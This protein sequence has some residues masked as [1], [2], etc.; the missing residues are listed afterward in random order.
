MATIEKPPFI[1][2]DLLAEMRARA[3]RAASGTRD[4]EDMRKAIERMNRM[5]EAMPETN[6]AVALVREARDQG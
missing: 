2:A 3:E 1:P 4:P 5:R 6:I